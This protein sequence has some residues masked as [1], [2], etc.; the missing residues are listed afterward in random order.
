MATPPVVYGRRLKPFSLCHSLTL[1]EFKSPILVGGEVALSDVYFASEVCRRNYSDLRRDLFSILT[2]RA[3]LKW[4]LRWFGIRN[5]TH[6]AIESLRQYIS[7]FSDS[8]LHV[9]PDKPRED[10][11][12][13]AAPYEY[14]LHRNLCECGYNPEAAWDVSISMARCLYDVRQEQDG[15]TTLHPQ[16]K[17]END[18]LFAEANRL[19]KSGNKSEADKLFAECERVIRENQ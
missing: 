4:A 14:V 8:P 15:D 6:I 10:Y 19:L 16:W 1:R 2:K 5:K 13:L 17:V 11:R 3:R 18:E 9:E 12:K 7:D